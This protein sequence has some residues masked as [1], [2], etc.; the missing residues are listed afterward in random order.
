MIWWGETIKLKKGKYNYILEY[1]IK[2]S[3]AYLNKMR[4]LGHHERSS[5]GQVDYFIRN[6]AISL[7]PDL[8]IEDGDI[9][10]VKGFKD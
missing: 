8:G 6:N 9:L 7:D 10:V 4:L 3:S 5:P 2:D 1:E